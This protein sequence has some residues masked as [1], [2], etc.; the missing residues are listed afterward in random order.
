M[1]NC[2][3]EE[4]EDLVV[5]VFHLVVAEEILLIV[6]KMVMLEYALVGNANI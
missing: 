2:V 3:G 6:I 1:T 5:N 4:G